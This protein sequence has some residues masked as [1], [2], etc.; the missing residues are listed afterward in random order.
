MAHWE[1]NWWTEK[2]GT[3]IICEVKNIVREALT[4]KW[5]TGR[6]ETGDKKRTKFKEEIMCQ[7]GCGGTGY[8]G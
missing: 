5:Q 8:L 2:Y 4:Q 3:C 7:G 1:L 6:R